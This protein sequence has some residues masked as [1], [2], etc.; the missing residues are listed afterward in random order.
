MAHCYF[1]G[2]VVDEAKAAISIH[3]LGVQRGFGIFDFFRSRNRQPTFV[4]DHLA[5]FDK[6]QQFLNLDRLISADEIL[7]AV[8]ELQQRNNFEEST[9]KLML[10]GDGVE[11]DALLR[12]FF[13]IINHPLTANQPPHASLILHEYLREY[14]EIKTINYLTSNLL[15]R[16]KQAAGAIDVLYHKDGIVSEASR[17]NLFVIRD[18][19]LITPASNVLQGVTRK[20]LMNLADKTMKVCTSDLTVEDVLMADEVFISSTL[21]EVLPITSIDG[22]QIGDGKPGQRT[23]N[24]RQQ[25]SD[26]I[27][28]SVDV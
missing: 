25:F 10:L 3:H 16:Q 1:N 9:F 13:Y 6:S 20:H 21:K 7:E 15:H 14:P 4:Q 24:L 8:A 17:S 23:L 26:Y 12:P 11:S 22:N 5:R 19:E 2:K 27:Q 28:E 18:G